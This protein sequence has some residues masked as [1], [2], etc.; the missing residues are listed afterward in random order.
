MQFNMYNPTLRDITGEDFERIEGYDLSDARRG[1]GDNLVDKPGMPTHVFLP[2]EMA[3]GDMRS[4][5]MKGK[6]AD[7]VVTLVIKLPNTIRVESAYLSGLSDRINELKRLSTGQAIITLAYSEE[8][9]QIFCKDD[10]DTGV[11][12]R[13][14]NY[15]Y[16]P[17]KKIRRAVV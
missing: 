14:P 6:L 12:P 17:V 9:G 2:S 15:E 1:V 10:V 13:L 3:A 4:E 7:L 16:Q 5:L 8:T 11:T